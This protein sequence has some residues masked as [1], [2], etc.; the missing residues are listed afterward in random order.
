MLKGETLKQATL[1]GNSITFSTSYHTKLIAAEFNDS[2]TAEVKVK[3]KFSLEWAMK[4]QR[5]SRGIAVLFH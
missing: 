2:L 5:G 4:A 1:S 3:V